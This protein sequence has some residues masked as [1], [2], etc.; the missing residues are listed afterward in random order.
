MFLPSHK[1]SPVTKSR[2]GK[3][4]E[5]TNTRVETGML[6]AEGGGGGGVE[7]SPREVYFG[8]TVVPV[9]MAAKQFN[10]LT[11]KMQRIEKE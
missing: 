11:S 2:Q 4:L 5:S 10:H 6:I 9:H 7:L 3:N 8:L 1:K